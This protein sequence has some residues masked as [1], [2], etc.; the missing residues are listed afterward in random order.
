MGKKELERTIDLLKKEINRLH[1]DLLQLRNDL[2]VERTKSLD[3]NLAL[4]DKEQEICNLQKEYD[5]GMK[6]ISS[7]VLLLE[8]NFRKEQTEILAILE[9]KDQAIEQLREELCARDKC[10]EERAKQFDEF[11]TQTQKELK[12]RDKKIASQWRE[13]EGY[14]GANNKFLGALNQLRSSSP[15]L[16]QRSVSNI[17]K[18]CQEM[19]STKPRNAITPNASRKKFRGSSDW[20][21]ELSAFF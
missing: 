4:N 10:L 5:Q 17:T 14:R 11:K 7:R 15:P 1:Q 13:L 20:R 8:G 3:L 12:A 21:E 18:S 2:K 19:H 9:S 6:D 16:V